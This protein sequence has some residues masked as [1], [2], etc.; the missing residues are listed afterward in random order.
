MLLTSQEIKALK[1]EIE[2][3][4]Y[5]IQSDLNELRKSCERIK[6]YKILARLCKDM[7]EE[8]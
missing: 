6:K 8:I 5:F 1:E 3:Y 7:I 4:E 2:F